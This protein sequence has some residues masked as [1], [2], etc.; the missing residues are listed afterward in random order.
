MW[1]IKYINMRK[2]VYAFYKPTLSINQNEEFACA[3]I[4]KASWENAG[5]ECVMLN[6]SHASGSSHYPLILG[7]FLW[8][9]RAG[10]GISE[11]TATRLQSRFGRW[12]ILTS[13]GG[14]W[15]TDYDVLNLGFTPAM[16]DKIEAETGLA[17]NKEGPAWI[18]YAT[19]QESYNACKDFVEKNLFKK[20]KPTE[21]E[22]ESKILGIKKDFFKGSK[23]LIHVSDENKSEKMK[24]LFTKYLQ[25]KTSIKKEKPTNRK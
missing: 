19:A 6:Q 22:T 20:K 14:G 23:K 21:T 11:E 9:I 16:A 3:N 15:M 1:D 12:G 7:K 18:I 2:K 8:L 25:P 13:V 5:W 24:E 10:V 4:W 17:I